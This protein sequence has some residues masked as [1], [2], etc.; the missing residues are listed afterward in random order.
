MS[1]AGE[2]LYH[3][4]RIGP[5]PSAIPHVHMMVI[6]GNAEERIIRVQFLCLDGRLQTSGGFVMLGTQYDNPH[7]AW[8]ILEN[9]NFHMMCGFPHVP[10][11]QLHHT[12]T[13]PHA[14]VASIKLCAG[15]A[16]QYE[17]SSLRLRMATRYA[18]PCQPNQLHSHC[19]SAGTK[20]HLIIITITLCLTECI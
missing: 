16:V 14:N 18:A 20:V 4:G 2:S 19:W 5:L 8:S 10:I 17:A 13:L 7:L 6:C 15:S 1:K 9:R 11:G 12:N 3:I